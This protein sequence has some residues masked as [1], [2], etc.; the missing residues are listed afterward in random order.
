MNTSLPSV[1]CE[2]PAV[3]L[4]DAD[5]IQ[6]LFCGT[7]GSMSVCENSTVTSEPCTRNM[8]E[9]ESG[10]SKWFTALQCR[11]SLSLGTTG[12]A[13]PMAHNDL[14][15]YLLAFRHRI[16]KGEKHTAASA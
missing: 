16:G 6:S 10:A 13:S 2:S 12:P 9:Q 11:V 15:Y 7:P 4:R 14:L 5:C 3:L 8:S 1:D